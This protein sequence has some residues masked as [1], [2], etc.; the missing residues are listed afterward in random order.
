[1]FAVVFEIHVRPRA[2]WLFGERTRMVRDQ[3]VRLRCAMQLNGAE[4]AK[5][6]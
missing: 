2:T 5:P 4:G 3:N 6:A 1:M